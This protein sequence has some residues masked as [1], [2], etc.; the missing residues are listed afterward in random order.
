VQAGQHRKGR[1][2][3][4]RRD[5]VGVASDEEGV[6]ERGQHEVDTAVGDDRRHIV[7]EPRRLAGRRGDQVRLVGA[8][9][10]ERRRHL[11]RVGHV[12][13]GARVVEGAHDRRGGR[14]APA[15]DEH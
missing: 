6:L 1:R 14:E 13:P 12:H 8:V 5:E 10:V 7:R 11:E 2:E 15:E 3:D 9:G 4:R